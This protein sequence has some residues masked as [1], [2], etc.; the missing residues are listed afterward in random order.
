MIIYRDNNQHILKN[1]YLILDSN[2][3]RLIYS[4]NGL[5]TQLYRAYMNSVLNVIFVPT[6]VSRA[7]IC[8][9]GLFTAIYILSTKTVPTGQ[10]V[11]PDTS[12]S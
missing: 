1:T 2:P 10:L 11:A 3:G 9:I 5:S 6:D 7:S 8:C 12:L 4:A